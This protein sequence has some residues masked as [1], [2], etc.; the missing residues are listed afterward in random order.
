MENQNHTRFEGSS[1]SRVR[2]KKISQ[3]N[4]YYKFSDDGYLQL[5]GKLQTQNDVELLLKQ[6]N[7]ILNNEM[8]IRNLRKDTRQKLA[9][10]LMQSQLP[11]PEYCQAKD[12]LEP[13]LKL[14]GQSKSRGR[15]HQKQ[16]EQIPLMKKRN[17][18][19]G[20]MEKTGKKTA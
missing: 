14:Q 7:L 3:T 1:S 6:L 8:E 19:C 12:E 4:T 10:S 13:E 18:S 11:I 20:K 9:T 5:I 17:G 16:L 15:L 2:L